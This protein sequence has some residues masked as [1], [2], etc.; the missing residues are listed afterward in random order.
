MPV[1]SPLVTIKTDAT[2]TRRRRATRARR[3][4]RRRA[5][6]IEQDDQSGCTISAARTPRRNAEDQIL[7]A[8]SRDPRA[9]QPEGVPMPARRIA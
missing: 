4:L 7:E 8:P 6:A 5:P 2:A 9:E 3:E 1:R